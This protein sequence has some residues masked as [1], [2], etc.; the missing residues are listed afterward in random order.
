M[1]SLKALAEEEARFEEDLLQVQEEGDL[2]GAAAHQLPLRPKWL[3]LF[4]HSRFQE[5]NPLRRCQRDQP[6]PNFYH[7]HNRK[8]SGKPNKRVLSSLSPMLLRKLLL[9]VSKFTW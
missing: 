2:R 4:R 8:T 3:Q 7:S 6:I 1:L 5:I 9:Q